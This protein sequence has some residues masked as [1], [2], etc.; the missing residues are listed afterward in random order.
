MMMMTLLFLCCFWNLEQVQQGRIFYC[1]FIGCW[2]T[3]FKIGL[4]WMWLMQM[5]CRWHGW[6]RGR[7]GVPLF[8]RW[9]RSEHWIC[10]FNSREERRSGIICGSLLIG[11][12]DEMIGA[13][14]SGSWW[15]WWGPC[16]WMERR[17]H[18][19]ENYTCKCNKKAVPSNRQKRLLVCSLEQ[20]ASGKRPPW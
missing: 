4:G 1:N 9:G 20:A 19:D 2:I 14:P 15:G 8:Q 16:L 12:E 17:W 3:D 10:T 7:L 13:F 18:N 6:E 11:N 5:A